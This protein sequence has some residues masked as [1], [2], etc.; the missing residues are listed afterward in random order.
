MG[1]FCGVGLFGDNE[2]SP[3]CLDGAM[4]FLKSKQHA[5]AFLREEMLNGPA[6]DDFHGVPGTSVFIQAFSA[7]REDKDLKGV[8][9][10][11]VVQHIKGYYW[12]RIPCTK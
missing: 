10:L 6:A 12:I 5:L 2:L 1:F 3:E 11:Y 9:T 7:A 4:R 8:E